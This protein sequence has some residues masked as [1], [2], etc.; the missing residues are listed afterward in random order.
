MKSFAIVIPCYN[1][2]NRFQTERF[3]AFLK[4]RTHVIMKPIVFK[5]SVLKHS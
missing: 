2:A 4:N 5:R 1:E 3:K